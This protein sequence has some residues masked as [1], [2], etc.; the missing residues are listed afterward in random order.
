MKKKIILVITLGI[1]FCIT[2]CG[3]EDN[4]KSRK[5]LKSGITGVIVYQGTPVNWAFAYI[6]PTKNTGFR[7]AFTEASEATKTNGK[8]TIS[9]LP[10]KYYL[11]ARKRWNYA[12]VGPLRTGDFEIIYYNN[13]VE[14]KE[15]QFVNAGEIEL[16]EIREEAD[17]IPEGAGISGKAF[18]PDKKSDDIFV[19]IYKNSDTDLMGP[20]YY[21]TKQVKSDGSFK[22][23]LLPGKYYFSARKRKSGSKLGPLEKE[24]Y[25][26]VYSKNP[27]NVLN[28][29][30]FNLGEILLTKIDPIKFDAIKA[31]TFSNKTFSMGIK[32]LITDKKGNKI[33]G[34][35]AFV[36]K[37]YQMIGK[38]LFRSSSTQKDGKYEIIINSPGIYYVG[39]RNTYGGPLEPGDL[40]GTYNGT[41]DHLLKIK[42]GEIIENINIVIEEFQ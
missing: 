34:I 21:I 5:G 26:Y 30:Y 24:D 35:Y 3:K 7:E 18:L 28:N 17:M 39:A 13:P 2:S 10:G 12:K 25:N 32:G 19:Y 23:N 16:N 9:A 40:V 1:F 6:Y 20:S 27:V 29:A 31:G 4:Q 41:P 37:D 42:E 22:I 14:I 38:P 8:F 11:V 33:E 36:Y 15:N